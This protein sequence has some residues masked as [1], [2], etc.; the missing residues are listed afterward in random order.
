MKVPRQSAADG[1]TLRA[2]WSAALTLW[3]GGPLASPADLWLGGMTHRLAADGMLGSAD[4]AA[5]PRASR[6]GYS[7]LSHLFDV[8]G[9]AEGLQSD[10]LSPERS[11][12]DRPPLSPPPPMVG[13]GFKDSDQ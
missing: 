9:R 13:T 7:S 8:L 10:C 6:A 3:G 5:M 12:P 4:R 1:F 11:G 2:V